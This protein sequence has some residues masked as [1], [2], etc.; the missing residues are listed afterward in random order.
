[1]QASYAIPGNAEGMAAP[2]GKAQGN[3]EEEEAAAASLP[4]P[5]FSPADAAPLEAMGVAEKRS[6]ILLDLYY[7]LLGVPSNASPSEIRRAYYALCKR[8]HPDNGAADAEELH[9]VQEAYRVLS[10][11]AKRIRLD[12]KD[13][14][15]TKEEQERKLVELQE[16]Q[17]LRANRDLQNMQIEYSQKLSREK[18]S[19]GV[20]VDEHL[21][22]PYMDVTIPLQCQIDNSR[23]VFPGGAAASFEQLKGFYNP[24]PLISGGDISL[25]VLYR[26]RGALHEVTV[27]DC[28][29]LAL[30]LKAEPTSLDPVC[31]CCHAQEHAKALSACVYVSVCAF[32]CGVLCA[33]H[34]CV[35]GVPRGPYAAC[36][37]SKLADE[38]T[39]LHCRASL[40]FRPAAASAAAAAAVVGLGAAQ[41]RRS[42]GWS[43][44]CFARW[45]HL[46]H[47]ASEVA[48]DT[49]GAQ[50]VSSACAREDSA[51]GKAAL[52]A[53]EMPTI[54]KAVSCAC[55]FAAAEAAEAGCMQTERTGKRAPPAGAT[56]MSGGEPA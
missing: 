23:F 44:D 2:A 43:V 24:A 4:L 28:S 55:P 21:E 38:M 51:S 25:Y 33:V 29:Q 10:D 56:C 42:C 46:P 27:S 6:S 20:I 16:L 7:S 47:F 5:A 22:G 32:A 18:A 12:I 31:V 54:P 30:P 34:L 3:V 13:R 17:R 41:T 8:L 11:E 36:N 9:K 49:L 15:Y 1:M 35:S 19:N 26:F 40:L 37:L 53:V 45:L 14:K 50:Q 48:V 52:N 39:V